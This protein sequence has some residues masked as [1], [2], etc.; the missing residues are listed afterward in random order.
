MTTGDRH[1]SPDYEPGPLELV[2]DHGAAG[3]VHHTSAHVDARGQP[4]LKISPTVLL[5]SGDVAS[6]HFCGSDFFSQRATPPPP[7][8]KAK[9]NTGTGQKMVQVEISHWK[10]L[11]LMPFKLIGVGKFSNI[12]GSRNISHRCRGVSPELRGMPL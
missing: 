8:K 12:G 5:T 3:M 6:L 9:K 2:D 7:P 1:S 11:Q 10:N 4:N